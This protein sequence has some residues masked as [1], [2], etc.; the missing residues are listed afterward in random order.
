MKCQA[1]FLWKVKKKKKKI[2]VSA[3]GVVI[4]ALKVNTKIDW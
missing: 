2:E 1:Y 4:S 3:G